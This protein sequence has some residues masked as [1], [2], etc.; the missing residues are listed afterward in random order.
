VKVGKILNRM[1]FGTA[2]GP[3][4]RG[5]L[6]ADHEDCS[7]E[8]LQSYFGPQNCEADGPRVRGGRS[9]VHEDCSPE[10]LKN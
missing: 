3:Q 1:K 2:D 6:S 4:V 7:P 8:A 9:A 10:A 5:G